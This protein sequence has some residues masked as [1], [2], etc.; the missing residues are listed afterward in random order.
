MSARSIGVGCAMGMVM[1][2]PIWPNRREREEESSHA[3]RKQVWLARER[4]KEGMDRKLVIQP[5]VGFLF[6]FLFFYFVLFQF[7]FKSELK[8]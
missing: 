4:K 5:S 7:K 8:V 2:Q 3:R 1:G 6:P